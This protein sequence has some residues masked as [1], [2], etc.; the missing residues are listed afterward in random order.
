MRATGEVLTDQMQDLFINDVFAA[1]ETDPTL[2]TAMPG[3]FAAVGDLCQQ[4]GL[5]DMTPATG[6]T[7][8]GGANHGRPRNLTSP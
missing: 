4:N 6:S 7:D 8:S 3:I 5:F 1:C 2:Q